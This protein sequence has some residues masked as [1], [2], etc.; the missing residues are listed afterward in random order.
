MQTFARILTL[1]PVVISLIVAVVF[2]KRS[3]K[4]E[5]QRTLPWYEKD[6]FWVSAV[7]SVT[8]IFAVVLWIFSYKIV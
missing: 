5:K 1:L 6:I 2:F 4:K 7:L 3:K 8:L